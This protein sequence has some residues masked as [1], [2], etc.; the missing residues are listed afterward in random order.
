VFRRDND[1]VCYASPKKIS[2]PSAFLSSGG[3]ELS[4]FDTFSPV[5]D[6]LAPFYTPE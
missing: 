6:L 4:K 5:K 3:V 1:R 2:S